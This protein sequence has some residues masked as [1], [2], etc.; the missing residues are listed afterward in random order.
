M[1]WALEGACVC[2]GIKIRC[3]T[4]F[5]LMKNHTSFSQR[6]PGSLFGSMGIERSLVFWIMAMSPFKV[7]C[8]ALELIILSDCH[9]FN[10]FAVKDLF[11]GSM[12][13]EDGACYP[14]RNHDGKGND[15]DQCQSEKNDCS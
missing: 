15:H 12:H 3:D 6:D 2:D 5:L 13:G 9:E 10:C 11:D 7:F 1:R 4:A 14:V 8:E